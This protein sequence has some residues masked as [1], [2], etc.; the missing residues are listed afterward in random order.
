MSQ[1]ILP[2]LSNSS[3]LSALNSYPQTGLC[4][5]DSV[6]QNVLTFGDQS[7]RGWVKWNDSLTWVSVSW[8]IVLFFSGDDALELVYSSQ[9]TAF[10][11]VYTSHKTKR[12][13][14][15]F[16]YLVLLGCKHVNIVRTPTYSLTQGQPNPRKS[17]SKVAFRPLFSHRKYCLVVWDWFHV[18]HRL[19]ET[20]PK[21]VLRKHPSPNTDPPSP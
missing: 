12:G 21:Q 1:N 9:K 3:Y 6:L 18:G 5:F 8:F 4:R 13:C 2:F 20:Q 10:D 15:Q 17:G 19:Q 16:I 11:L 14:S 7:G